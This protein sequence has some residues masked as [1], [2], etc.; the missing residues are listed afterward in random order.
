MAEA[1]EDMAMEELDN[2]SDNISDKRGKN[3]C[4]SLEDFLLFLSYWSQAILL[5]TRI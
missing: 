3:P 2:K 4:W 1:H 5:V